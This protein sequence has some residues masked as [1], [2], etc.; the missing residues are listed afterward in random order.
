MQ[1]S[2]A[3]SGI[4]MT[5]QRTVMEFNKGHSVR[6]PSPIEVRDRGRQTDFRDVQLFKALSPSS[7]KLDGIVIFLIDELLAKPH[8]PMLVT[9]EGREISYKLELCKMN[10]SRN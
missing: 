9:V 2:K 3:L 10:T 5:L 7:S 8:A 6:V 4:D 1:S